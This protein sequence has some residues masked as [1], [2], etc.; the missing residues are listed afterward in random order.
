MATLSCSVRV[1][2]RTGIFRSSAPEVFAA[3]V[4][5]AEIA[6]TTTTVGSTVAMAMTTMSVWTGLMVMTMTMSVWTGVMAMTMTM[7]GLIGAMMTRTAG[8]SVRNGVAT[9]GVKDT[10]D[11]KGETRS[12]LKS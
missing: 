11:T 7:N 3:T 8:S 9:G 6:V 5:S 2:M 10:K 1:G 12:L 4:A